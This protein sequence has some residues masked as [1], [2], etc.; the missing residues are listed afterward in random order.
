MKLIAT[1]HT[2]HQIFSN[3]WNTENKLEVNGIFQYDD[4]LWIVKEITSIEHHY[5]IAHIEEYE[6][7]IID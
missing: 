2:G 1:D 6:P 4:T 5:I 7:I 3:P